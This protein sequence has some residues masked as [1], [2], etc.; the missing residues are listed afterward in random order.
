MRDTLSK[1][2]VEL[3]ENK[4]SPLRRMAPS[5]FASLHR[6]ESSPNRILCRHQS[7]EIGFAFYAPFCGQLIPL[8]F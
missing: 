6:D 7:N 5:V 2:G 4:P 8:H 1:E 3:K